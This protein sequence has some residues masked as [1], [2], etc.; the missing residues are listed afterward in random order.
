MSRRKTHDLDA[1][2]LLLDLSIMQT[3]LLEMAKSMHEGKT[4]QVA[5]AVLRKQRPPHPRWRK[6]MKA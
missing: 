3:N 4:S 5:K 2:A 6:R 1:P